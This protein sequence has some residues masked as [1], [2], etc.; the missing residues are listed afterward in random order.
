MFTSNAVKPNKT[1]TELFLLQ[2]IIENEGCRYEGDIKINCLG[3][4][5]DNAVV[6]RYFF[7]CLVSNGSR[8]ALIY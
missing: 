5:K 8:C 4:K 2:S 7:I 1:E 6:G 3:P